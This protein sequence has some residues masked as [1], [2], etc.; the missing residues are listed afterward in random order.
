VELPTGQIEPSKISSDQIAA[1]QRLG[2]GGEIGAVAQRRAGQLE[3]L[4]L[5]IGHWQS[6]LGVT[7]R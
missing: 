1:H 3:V 2:A 5:V 4:H 7:D 6:S